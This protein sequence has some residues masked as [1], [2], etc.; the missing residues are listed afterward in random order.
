[1]YL[2]FRARTFSS[3]CFDA[4]TVFA[5]FSFFLT[6]LDLILELE[7][8]AGRK[9]RDISDQEMLDRNATLASHFMMRGFLNTWDIS[10]KSKS[11]NC[12][13]KVFCEGIYEASKLGSIGQEIAKISR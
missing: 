10:S 2:F 3:S 1:M 8:D 9:K 4:F 12:Q 6:L 11:Q 7:G 13:Q 5:F